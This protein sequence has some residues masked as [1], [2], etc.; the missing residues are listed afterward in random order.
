M[1]PITLYFHG[2]S[3]N[4]WKVAMILEELNLPYIKKDVSFTEIKK[5]PYV[6]IN[7]NGRLPAIQDPNTDLTLWESGAIIEYLVETYDTNHKISFERGSEA[8]FHVKQFLHFQVS[9]QGP[10][11]GQALWFLYQHPEKVVSAQERYINQV[12]R[13]TEVLDSVLEGKEYL[14][15]ERFSYVDAAFVPWY[16]PVPSV[17]GNAIDLEELFP[18]VRSW[19]ERV[20]RRPAIAKILGERDKALAAEAAE[21]K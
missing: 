15:S 14:V 7:P 1:Q 21:K 2:S 10:Y 5:E 11:F 3:P 18:N 17:S 9:G 12:K 19:L 4:P 6:L 8:Y 20:R 16:E 13:V